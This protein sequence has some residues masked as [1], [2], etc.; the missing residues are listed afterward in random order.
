M[1]SSRFS[2]CQVCDIIAGDD[3]ESEYM[4]PGS[5]DELEIGETGMGETGERVNY[6]DREEQGD[7]GEIIDY[8]DRA[9]MDTSDEDTDKGKSNEE[10][11]EEEEEEEEEDG[12]GGRTS[13]RHGGAGSSYGVL[14]PD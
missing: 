13:T 14:R 6:F 10:S 1:A 9:Q 4:F 11:L 12:D 3:G 8:L 2:V 5:D 7:S